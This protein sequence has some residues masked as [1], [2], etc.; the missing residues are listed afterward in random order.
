[1]KSVTDIF[2]LQIHSKRNKSDHKTLQK[3]S[4]ENRE[5]IDI[6]NHRTTILEK[7]AILPVVLCKT[8]SN[9]RCILWPIY[10]VGV[11]NRANASAS[12]FAN[13]LDAI[14]YWHV[15]QWHRTQRAA[16][17]IQGTGKFPHYHSNDV[18]EYGSW[19]CQMMDK[20]IDTHC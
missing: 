7:V 2:L 13:F 11:I 16:N 20:K 5:K 10:K 14:V 3:C 15:I 6:V 9:V 19:R 17:N 1:M 18:S 8:K 12:Q 4:V